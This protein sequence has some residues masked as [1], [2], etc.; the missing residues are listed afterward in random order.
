MRGIFKSIFFVLLNYFYKFEPKQ[1]CNWLKKI[2]FL[3]QINL[4]KILN[5]Y[6]LQLKKWADFIYNEDIIND[7]AL[8][9]A[10]LLGEIFGIFKAFNS[11]KQ[12]NEI[13]DIM[14]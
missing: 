9:F 8:K 3:R 14:I 1:S 5:M 2:V 4:T 12:Q 13:L 6:N 11:I 7:N 10:E